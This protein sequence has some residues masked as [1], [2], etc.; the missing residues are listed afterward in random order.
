MGSLKPLL[1]ASLEFQNP[2]NSQPLIQVDTVWNYLVNS[3]L[4]LFIVIR[5]PGEHENPGTQSRNS[6]IM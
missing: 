1:V 4:H 3:L 2:P 5:V 6:A